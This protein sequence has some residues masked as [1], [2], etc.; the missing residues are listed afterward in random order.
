MS[1]ST[2]SSAFEDSDPL[3]PVGFECDNLVM[4]YDKQSS[5]AANDTLQLLKNSAEVTFCQNGEKQG[6]TAS[7]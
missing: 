7:Q 2:N 6:E 3:Q 5:Q 1:F 4:T